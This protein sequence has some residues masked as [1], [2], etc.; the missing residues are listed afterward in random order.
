MP[1]ASDRGRITMQLT[2]LYDRF[3]S[4]LSMTHMTANVAKLPIE[5]RNG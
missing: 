2:A 5:P 1:S 3:P 4:H